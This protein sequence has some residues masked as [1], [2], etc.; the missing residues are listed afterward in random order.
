MTPIIVTVAT[1]AFLRR[2]RAFVSSLFLSTAYSTPF[3]MGL[4]S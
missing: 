4:L 2:F 1:V 3:L